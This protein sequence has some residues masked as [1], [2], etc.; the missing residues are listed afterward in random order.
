MTV[1]YEEIKALYPGSTHRVSR[2]FI[3]SK[4]FNWIEDFGPMG[5]M[6]PCT[7]YVLQGEVTYQFGDQKINISEGECKELPGGEYTL[8]IGEGDVEI[9]NVWKLPFDT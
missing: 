6:M 4:E 7:C 2:N 9:V 5:T 3:K 8:H 1:T